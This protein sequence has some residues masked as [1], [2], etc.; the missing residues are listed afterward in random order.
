MHTDG[1]IYPVMADMQEAGAD[2]INPQ[3]RANGL[4]NLVRVC[5]GKIPICLDLDRQLFPF[6]TP[7]QVGRHIRECT[8]ALYMP[9]GG[10][11]L[12]AE[13]AADV[14]LENIEAICDA[15][16]WSSGYRG[17]AVADVNP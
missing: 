11:M 13:C 16:T 12:T 17:S 3:I 14:P 9:E 10:L 2:I 7:E 6:A 8:E 5:K 15:L 4:D 1:C